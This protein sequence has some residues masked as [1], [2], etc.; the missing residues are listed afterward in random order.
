MGDKKVGIVTGGSRGIGRACAIELA[1]SGLDV[2]I[3]YAGN[4]EAAEKTVA[5]LK[6][7]GSNSKAYK[8]DVGNYNEVQENISKI[9]MF[10][11]LSN[12]LISAT[13]ISS[14]TDRPSPSLR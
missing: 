11:F 14:L 9:S 4:T 10:V 2:V 1:R 3:T 7:M 12:P 6:A 8:F 5:E 13:P